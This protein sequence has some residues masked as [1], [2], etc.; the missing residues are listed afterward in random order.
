MRLPYSMRP[1]ARTRPGGA[2]MTGSAR[3]GGLSAAGPLTGPPPPGA[4]GGTI[5]PPP[6]SNSSDAASYTHS[7][8]ITEMQILYT[9]HLDKPKRKETQ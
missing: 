5:Y 1:S 6:Q 4:N 9:G 3:R 2:M 8:D 7:H